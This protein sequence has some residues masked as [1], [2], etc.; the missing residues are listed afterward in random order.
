MQNTVNV[1][2]VDDNHMSDFYQYNRQ[3]AAVARMLLENHKY[4]KIGSFNYPGTGADVAEYVF[5]LTNNPSRQDSRNMYYGP[6]RS[7]SVGDIVEVNGVKFL[8]DSMGWVEV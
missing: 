1:L 8:C 4:R 7:V 2:L 3:P 5:D 6:Y